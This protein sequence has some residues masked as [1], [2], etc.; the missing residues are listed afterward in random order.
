[1]T[2]EFTKRGPAFYS[3]LDFVAANGGGPVGLAG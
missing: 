3:E 2:A 1:M